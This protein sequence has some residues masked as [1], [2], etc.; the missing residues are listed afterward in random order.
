MLLPI[1]GGYFKTEKGTKLSNQYLSD[2]KW[3]EKLVDKQIA[4]FESNQIEAFPQDLGDEKLDN[5]GSE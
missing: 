1:A 4:K 5:R 3:L 2:A